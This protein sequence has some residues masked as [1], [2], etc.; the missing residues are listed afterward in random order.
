MA[1]ATSRRD[2]RLF[3][4]GARS[5]DGATAETLSLSLTCTTITTLEC[6]CVH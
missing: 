5:R 3:M 1:L 6:S 4:T 2:D